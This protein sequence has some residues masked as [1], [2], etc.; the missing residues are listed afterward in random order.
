MGIGL[1]LVKRLVEL[2]DGQVAV[3]SKG[4]GQG[5]TF[6]VRLPTLEVAP[7]IIP[8]PNGENPAKGASSDRILV[9]DDNADAAQTLSML[10]KLKGFQV[11]TRN[12]GQSGI[13]AAQELSPRAI[14]LDLGMP[15]MDGYETC[16]LIRQQTWGQ[17]VVV[18]A[19]SGYGQQEDHQRTKEM[20]FDEHLVK[21]VDLNELTNLLTRLLDSGRSVS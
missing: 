7:Q 5:S 13:E 19:L 17:T 2:H 20:G 3:R 11:H 10:L 16:R 15:G 12:S 14:L 21:P 8:A 9:I 1:T 4:L 18:I 6:S